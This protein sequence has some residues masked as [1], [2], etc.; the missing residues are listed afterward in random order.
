M[1]IKL[2]D[3]ERSARTKPVGYLDAVLRVG[4][5]D[6]DYVVLSYVSYVRLCARFKQYGDAVEAV[7]KPVAL[8]LKLPCY[9]EKKHL[10][11]DSGCAKRKA[12]LNREK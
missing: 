5:I 3:L 10:R 8:A 9:D 6:G 4:R 11:A 2:D 1:K 7:A 12:K